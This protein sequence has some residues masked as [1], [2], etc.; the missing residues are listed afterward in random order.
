MCQVL[1]LFV[2][3][4]V[5]ITHQFWC[6][7]FYTWAFKP[8]HFRKGV[9]YGHPFTP[10]YLDLEFFS[11]ISRRRNKKYSSHSLYVL[12]SYVEGQ[13]PTFMWL[14]SWLICA[15]SPAWFLMCTPSL[16]HTLV[17]YYEHATSLH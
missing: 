5:F 14:Y 17:S 12:C 15:A 2:F 7:A 1:C 10:L 3:N 6:L 8:F 4:S 11:T 13:F 9:K 16:K